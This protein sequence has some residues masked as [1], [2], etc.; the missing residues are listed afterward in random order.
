M[1]SF[2]TVDFGE[3]EE[4]NNTAED[5]KEAQRLSDL[6]AAS[7]VA[8]NLL[9]VLPTKRPPPNV[10]AHNAYNCSR[11]S[12]GASKLSLNFIIQTA[13]HLYFILKLCK[14]FRTW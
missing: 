10:S 6:A 3:W 5:A 9:G 4:G 2:S 13:L 7:I 1:Y 8:D 14:Y 11:R 12:S